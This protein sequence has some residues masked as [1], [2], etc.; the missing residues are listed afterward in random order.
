MREPVSMS[1]HN[2]NNGPLQATYTAYS[3]DYPNDFMQDESC[4]QALNEAIKH[5]ERAENNQ[6]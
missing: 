6:Q 5:L 1:G 4:V 2:N 3:R